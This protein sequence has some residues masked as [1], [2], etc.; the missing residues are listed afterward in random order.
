M[1]VLVLSDI[2]GNIS[3]LNEVLYQIPA[4]DKVVCCGDIVGYYPDVNEVC[5]KLKDIEASV[6]Q[7]N[8]DFYLTEECESVHNKSNLYNLKW[9][10][11]T[12]S[13]DNYKWLQKL[14]QELTFHWDDY[15]LH[16]RHASPWD[17]TTYLYPDSLDIDKI[18]L[19][20]NEILF[21]GHTH[22]PMEK[23]AGEG[24][25]INPGSVGQPRDNNLYASCAIFDT[26]SGE[27]KIHRIQYDVEAF[28]QRLNKMGWQKELIEIL[29]RK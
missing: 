26:H 1:K 28:Q 27:V 3:A 12:I 10:Q 6:I 25:L 23:I 29:R 21:V 19:K 11:E 24:R 13:M 7:G 4:C 15:F 2:H 9:S 14:P 22:Y 20:K 18:K 5:D 16:I 17:Q 8:H